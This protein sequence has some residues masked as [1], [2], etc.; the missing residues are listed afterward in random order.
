VL[1]ASTASGLLV[2]RRLDH[3]DLMEVLKSRE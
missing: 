3:L 2:R 1:L